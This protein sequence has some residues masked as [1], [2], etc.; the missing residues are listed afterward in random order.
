[1]RTLRPMLVAALAAATALALAAC[2]PGASATK[3]ADTGATVDVGLYLEPTD[4]NV[5]TTS[6][7]ALDQVLID[8]VYQGLVG[9]DTSGRIHDVLAKNHTVS[10]DG[11][12]YDFT[13]HD[14]ARFSNGHALDAADVVWSLEQVRRTKTDVGNA[15]LTAVRTITAPTDSTVRLTLTKPDS[16]LLYALAGRAGLVLDEQAKN[17]LKTTAIGSGP[18]LLTS[19]KQGDS[20]TLVRN[21]TYWGTKAKVASVV[22]HYF[23]DR[24][25]AVNAAL[26]G[27]LEVLTTVDPT[28][29]AKF[30]GNQDFRLEQGASTD[31]YTLVFNEKEGPL[32]SLAVRKALRQAIDPKAIIAAVGGDGVAQGGPIPKG[33]PGYRDLT[34]ID[35]YDPAAAKAAIAAAGL[36]GTTLTLTVPTVYGT[37]VSD[38]LTSEFKAVGIT[39]KVSSVDFTTWLTKVY[40]NKDYELSFVDHAEA[41]DFANWTTPGYYFNYSD[42]Q[43]DRLAA[44]A[45]TALTASEADAKL[46]QAARIVA[47]H[48]PAAWLYTAINQTA[49]RTT[50]HG[51]PTDFTSNRLN[52]ADLAVTN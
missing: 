27:D 48:A 14:G 43:V 1:M 3:G 41:H 47:E 31:K 51:F 49:I 2:S 34:S 15:D 26:N 28:L 38:V 46:A 33:D 5:R 45:R 7:V 42:P 39:L 17:D 18:Y 8:N 16:E 52:L 23:S 35:P 29:K 36:T 25:T 20:I 12:T 19:W 4:L 44:Q 6:G 50:V 11:L 10:A 21:T 9:L 24:S 37:T 30:E 32:T 40:T 22:L 13:L